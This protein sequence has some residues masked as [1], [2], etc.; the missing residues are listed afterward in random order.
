MVVCPADGSFVQNQVLTVEEFQRQNF[1][2]REEGSGTRE[3]FERTI[4]NVG[5]SV[6]PTWEAMST[7]SLVNAVINGLGITVLPRRMVSH[8]LENGLVVTVK[9]EGL[10]FLRRFK[11]IYHREK[12][13]SSS[14]KAFLGLCRGY[15]AEH[16][17]R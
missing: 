6:T 4:G 8:P 17:Y 13:L 9:V 5:I 12:L 7:S 15:K 14:A 10:N 2:L 16:S 11:I 1:L 3:V